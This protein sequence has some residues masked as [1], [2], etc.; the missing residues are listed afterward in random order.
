MIKIEKIKRPGTLQ[1]LAYE[2]IKGLLVSGQLDFDEIY[3]ANQF[4]AKLGVSRTPIR[5]ALLQLTAEG[6]LISVQGR[7]F[8]IKEH[9]E[10]EIMDFFE[11]RKMIEAYVIERLVNELTEKDL[12]D[13]EGILAEMRNSAKSGDSLSFLEADKTFHMSIVHRYKNQLLETTM[14]NIRNLISIFGG[15]ALMSPG[16]IQEV[17]DEHYKILE[18]LNK[19]DKNMA[20]QSMNYHLVA[21]EKSLLEDL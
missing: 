12:K 4:A 18:A 20:V 11:A 21:T 16:R 17:I 13:L 15:K 14:E 6:M 2:N 10:K 9:S 7:G 1:A 5:E 3:S 8:K 19:K